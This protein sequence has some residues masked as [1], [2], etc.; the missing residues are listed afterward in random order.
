[1]KNLHFH[2]FVKTPGLLPIC[3]HNNTSRVVYYQMLGGLRLVY[4]EW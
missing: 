3:D 1:M 2:A 4:L